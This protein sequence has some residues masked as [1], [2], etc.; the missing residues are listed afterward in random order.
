[1]QRS[2]RRTASRYFQRCRRRTSRIPQI[3]QSGGKQNPDDTPTKGEPETPHRVGRAR[4]LQLTNQQG[5]LSASAWVGS[6]R[7]IG[8]KS[9]S[10]CALHPGRSSKANDEPDV[11][12]RLSHP[13]TTSRRATTQFQR[14]ANHGSVKSFGLTISKWG[15]FVLKTANKSAN[16]GDRPYRPMSALPA[17]AMAKIFSGSTT[18]IRVARSAND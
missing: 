17:I 14:R 2:S 9:R 1:M 3:P 11:R 5:G 7:R 15:G 18:L 12:I 6:A 13:R 16:Y 4:R 10:G 8:L